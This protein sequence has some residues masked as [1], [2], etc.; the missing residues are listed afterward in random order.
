M[1]DLHPF[2][3][4]LEGCAVDAVRQERLDVLVV[5]LS[6][7]RPLSTLMLATSV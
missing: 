2:F 3:V 6:L 1:E 4:R 7:P 5:P